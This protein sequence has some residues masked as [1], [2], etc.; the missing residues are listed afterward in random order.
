MPDRRATDLFEHKKRE[1]KCESRV[2]RGNQ[3]R[4]EVR[5]FLPERTSEH[6]GKS[7]MRAGEGA[8]N[9]RTTGRVSFERNC[10]NNTHA[11]VIPV[12]QTSG[13]KPTS[14]TSD[15]SAKHE[16]T[17]VITKGLCHVR[18]VSQ[19][20]DSTLRQSDK[21]EGTSGGITIDTLMTPMFPFNT[22]HIARL[23]T[24]DQ[25]VRER[26]NEI[27]DTHSLGVRGEREREHASRQQCGLTRRD[28]QEERAFSLFCPRCGSN[29]A[30]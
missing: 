27:M 3:G 11:T 30:Q 8:T 26:P 25:K 29:E 16:R 21:H 20:S 24:K 1:Q 9:E 13:I 22:P 23:I 2:C 18:A 6:G 14:Q 15:G 7:I 4:Q 28:Q 17:G 5:V 12:A 19:V 10:A